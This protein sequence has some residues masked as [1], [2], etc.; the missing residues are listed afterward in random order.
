[1]VED[2]GMFAG[3]ELVHSY[4]RQQAI[5]DGILV[6]CSELAM[7]AGFKFP[8]AVTSTVWH[9]TIEPSEKEVEC[10]Q[11]AAGRLW[12]MLSVLRYGI[13]ACKPGTDILLFTMLVMD[14]YANLN[15]VQLKA[16]VGPGDD[17]S[18]VLTVMY[19]QED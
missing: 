2:K 19:P 6:D 14:E 17:L 1:M 11:S 8:L 13:N 16:V 3:M 15:E 4:S 10:G 12:D 7:E 18:P 5:E 9:E